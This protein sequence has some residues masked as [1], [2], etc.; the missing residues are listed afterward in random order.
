[1]AT[2]WERLGDMLGGGGRRRAQGAYDQRIGDLLVMGNRDQQLQQAIME[3]TARRGIGERLAGSG[4]APEQAALGEYILQGGMGSDYS[5]L[6][7]GLGR[8]QEQ[9]F[10]QSAVDAPDLA[11]ANRY[12]MGVA[13][14][15]QDLTKISGGVAYNPL[16]APGTSA[17]PTTAVGDSVI[18]ANQA[19]AGQR[20]ASAN[21]SNVKAAAGGFSP[22]SSGGGKTGK[23]TQPN[24][25]A[26][27]RAFEAADPNNRFAGPVFDQE[28]YLDFIQWWEQ[29][30]QF[31]D[32]NQALAQYQIAAAGSGLSPIFVDPSMPG[33][34]RPQA[35]AQ[36]Q[37]KADYDALPP[38][39]QY[40]AP[41]GSMR[42][43]G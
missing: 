33:Q 38:G 20:N 30:P 17:M 19:L 39:A 35:P 40:V 31:A 14:S 2:G 16:E 1:M 37:S 13:N 34:P 6:T 28:R 27:K 3:T 32:G 11:T 42:I 8:V 29:N 9:G 24:E 18:G 21:L 36:P 26:L 23:R 7:Q 25:A 12:L 22:S 41:D 5:S 43:K 10:R 4:M 15:P